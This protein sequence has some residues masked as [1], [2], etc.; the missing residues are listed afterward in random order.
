MP[1]DEDIGL[2][3]RVEQRERPAEARRQQMVQAVGEVGGLRIALADLLL[4]PGE[5]GRRVA[6]ALGEDERPLVGAVEVG[7]QR[8]HPCDLRGGIA[9][10]TPDDAGGHP[11]GAHVQRRQ[12]LELVLDHV[13]QE[14]PVRAG[15]E[16]RGQRVI[17][18][19]RVAD[20]DEQ[21]PGLHELV[22][23][24]LEAQTEQRP[25][26]EQVPRHPGALHVPD[27][28]PAPG[29]VAAERASREQPGERQPEPAAHF[30]EHEPPAHEHESHRHPRLARAQPEPEVDERTREQ[31]KRQQRREHHEQDALDE[32]APR[33]VERPGAGRLLCGQQRNGERGRLGRKRHGPRA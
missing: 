17:D 25:H 10:S 9:G 12:H 28:P 2:G 5:L 11:A 26:P 20:E 7:R 1:E 32:D 33:D 4:R 18:D 14:H 19:A 30:A 3:A 22:A 29:R 15:D 27:V 6:R 21:R 23:L 31:Q 16:D 24:D 13:A 8:A